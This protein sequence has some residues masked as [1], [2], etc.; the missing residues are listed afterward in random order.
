MSEKIDRR[1]ILEVIID[2]D[3][4]TLRFVTHIYRKV[5]RWIAKRR[6]LNINN[7]VTRRRLGLSKKK[8]E[9]K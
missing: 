6:W 2:K 1:E 4:H 7:P 3:N 8:E 5:P 9:I